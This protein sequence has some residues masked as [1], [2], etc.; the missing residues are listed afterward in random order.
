MSRG[1]AEEFLVATAVVKDTIGKTFESSGGQNL[2][3]VFIV[4]FA[5]FGVYNLHRH[6]TSLNS[7]NLKNRHHPTY[8]QVN[9]SCFVFYS[10]RVTQWIRRCQCS[11]SVTDHAWTTN[12]VDT[13]SDAVRRTMVGRR[14]SSITNRPTLVELN[15]RTRRDT[16]SLPTYTNV[17]SLFFFLL[18]L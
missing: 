8:G 15:V 16:N 14:N 3:S 6:V 17:F 18:F 11:A 12:P 13:V 9:Y 4:F 10:R 1:R 7:K 2:M 5:E